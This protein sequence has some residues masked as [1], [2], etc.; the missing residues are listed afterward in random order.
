M[1][2]EFIPVWDLDERWKEVSPLVEL[3]LAKQSAM[4][5]ESLFADCK[6]GKFHVWLIPGEVAF[7]TE[8]QQFPLE[9]ICMIVLAGGEGV[10]RWKN[11]CDQTL[12]RYAKAYGCVA[13]MIVGRRGWSA[14]MPEYQIQD[15]V[16][17]KNL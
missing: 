5:M 7:I 1:R 14:V 6:R 15:Y 12:T 9:R 8:V 2:L 16:M 13:L 4:N 3:A 10:D 11:V 17:R